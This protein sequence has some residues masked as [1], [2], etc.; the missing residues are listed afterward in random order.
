MA[1]EMAKKFRDRDIL[2]AMQSLVGYE[3]AVRGYNGKYGI[4]TPNIV[5][6]LGF[7]ELQDDKADEKADMWFEGVDPYLKACLWLYEA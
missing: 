1:V 2:N 5:K 6:D 7:V 3:C 4:R